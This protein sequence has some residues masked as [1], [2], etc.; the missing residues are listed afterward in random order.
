MDLKALHLKNVNK[1]ILAHLNINSLRNKFQFLI[2]LIKDNIDV[3]MISE[4]K[5]DGSFPTSQ[6]MIN[7]FSAPF[8]LDR[9]YKSGGIILYIREGIPSRLV[10]TESGQVKGFFVEINLRNK[11]FGYSVALIIQRK[12]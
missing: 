1:L 10:S 9:N 12:I 7:G 6:F 8:R 4:T 2:S 5:L 11:K 3:L